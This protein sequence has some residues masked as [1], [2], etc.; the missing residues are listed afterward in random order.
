M[1]IYNYSS[2]QKRDTK[3]Y[4]VGGYNIAGGFSV[5]FLKVVGPVALAIIA[6][7][8][9]LSLPFGISFFNPFSAN[10]V[11]W[12][13]VLWLI[14]GIGTGCGLWYIQFAGYRLYQY[15]GAYFKPKKVYMND[16]KHS[17][18]HLTD[19]KIK[20]FVKNIL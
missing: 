4:N 16:F 1:I 18:F 2:L 5:E 15:L 19:I 9:L 3:I 8:F 13:T 12:Y 6:V 17:E 7:G 20:A 14:L 11:T 10:F